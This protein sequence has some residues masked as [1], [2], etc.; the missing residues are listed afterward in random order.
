MSDCAVDAGH[1][2][3]YLGDAVVVLCPCCVS[4]PPSLL[5]ASISVSCMR[6]WMVDASVPS[7]NHCICFIVTLS[8]LVFNLV[9]ATFASRNAS[10]ATR[11]INSHQTKKNAPTS[12]FLI[13]ECSPPI[14][15]KFVYIRYYSS[16]MQCMICFR[17]LQEHVDRSF[18]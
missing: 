11:P 12:K 8:M 15:I 7:C 5:G 6:A 1:K 14:W 17:L 9:L 4:L 18:S 10:K 2:P 3:V 16:L 13:V